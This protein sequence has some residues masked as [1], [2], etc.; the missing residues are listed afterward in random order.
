L[1]KRILRLAIPNILSN[2]AIPLQGIV[3][4][5]LMGHLEDEVY[6][7][8]IGLG[9][10]L[11]A[12]IYWGLGFIRMGTTGLVAQAYGRQDQNTVT[13][14]LF[15]A[16]GVALL[17]AAIVLLFRQ[18]IVTLAFDYMIDGEADTE[19]LAG[20]YFFIRVLAAP[21]ALSL[22]AFKGWF[23]GMQN[24]RFPLI[25][26]LAVTLS[27]IVFSFW[28]VEGMGMT[29]D[30]VAYGTLCAQYIGLAT[31]LV[32][33]RI[34]YLKELLW[35]KK[36]KQEIFE[37]KAL[38]HFFSI[39][40][41]IFLR[42][43]ALTFAF[44][45][46]DVKSAEA[47]NTTLAVNK[48]LNQMLFLISYGVDGFAFAAESIVGRY[49]G[50]KEGDKLRKA[51]RLLMIWGMGLGAVFSLVYAVGGTWILRVFTSQEHLLEAA[52]LYLP[53]MI[54]LPLLSSAAFLW[55]GIYIGAVA[56]RTLL[57]MMLLS[58]FVVFLPVYYISFPLWENHGLWLAMSAFM[59][60]RSLFLSIM[61]KK[62][63]YF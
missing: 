27:N 40:S 17:A 39:N 4:T 52:Y 1:N 2:L 16:L 33:L 21:A 26:T 10:T 47:G 8:A 18:G 31:C 37:I 51:I 30:G 23:L 3:D 41:D 43:L 45:F 61:A 9:A 59:L 32:L 22:F 58:T 36:I 35:V 63:I 54:L 46:F 55:D 12:I 6:I 24:A 14:T 57:Y 60:S 48:I 5:A 29:S 13:L 11:F 42:T 15:R 38:R 28:F 25:L 34:R 62:V 53:W 20:E 50:S 44:T 49:V 56:T 7:G 19:R